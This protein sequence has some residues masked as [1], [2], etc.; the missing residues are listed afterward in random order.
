MKKLRSGLDLKKEIIQNIEKGPLSL[1]KLERKLN[2][3]NKTILMHIKEL[4]YLGVVTLIKTREKSRNGRPYT[5]VELTEYG[6][7]LK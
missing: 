3:N 1:R 2:T 5:I 6:N 7:K 4:E